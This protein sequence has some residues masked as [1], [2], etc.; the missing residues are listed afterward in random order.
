M[1]VQIVELVDFQNLNGQECLT[2]YHFADATGVLDPGNLAANYQADVLP[3]MVSFQSSD[4][5]HY[6]L[7]VRRV[8]PTADLGLDHAI[9]PTVPGGVSGT[10]DMPGFT[11]FSIKWQIGPTT[12]LVAGRTDHIKRG[13]KHLP[14]MRESQAHGDTIV[15]ANTIAFCADYVTA[16]L[17]MDAGGWDLVV[18]SFVTPGSPSVTHKTVQGYAPVLAGSPPSPGTQ[19]TRKVLRGRTF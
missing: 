17:N 11:S 14:G 15:D 2:V 3:E 8:Y 5:F 4:L 7:R 16:L 19:N 1:P 9:T 12:W 6:N 13:G 10:D 18:A